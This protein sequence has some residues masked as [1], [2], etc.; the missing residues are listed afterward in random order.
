MRWNQGARVGNVAAGSPRASRTCTRVSSGRN[1][2]GKQTVKVGAGAIVGIASPSRCGD[3]KPREQR[4]CVAL[5]GLWRRRGLLRGREA[6]DLCLELLD[7]ELEVGDAGGGQAFVGA[8]DKVVNLG[9][10]LL[11]PRVDLVLVYAP[12]AL[13]LGKDEVEEKEEAEVAVEGDP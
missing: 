7:G 10:V 8:R 4:L 1:S 6:E 5:R 13:G 12:G 9:L 3:A 11:E 2:T